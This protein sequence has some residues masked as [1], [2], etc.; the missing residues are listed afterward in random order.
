VVVGRWSAVV[1]RTTG[2]IV[3][4]RFWMRRGEA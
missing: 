1:G 3:C 4:A 2:A